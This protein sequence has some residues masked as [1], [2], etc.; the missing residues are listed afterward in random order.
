[1]LCLCRL[2]HCSHVYQRAEAL[3]VLFLVD[4][5]MLSQLVF[6]DLL[7][8]EPQ[9]DLLLSTLDGVGAVADVAADVLRNISSLQRNDGKG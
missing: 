1:M 2:C 3:R 6:K 5:F 9:S 7:R 4:P 8:F